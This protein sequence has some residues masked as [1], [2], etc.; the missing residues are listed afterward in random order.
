MLPIGR[1]QHVDGD[2]YVSIDAPPWENGG[3]VCNLDCAIFAGLNCI[4]EKSEPFDYLV[5]D[6]TGR[7]AAVK[8]CCPAR[9]R[10]PEGTDPKKPI[11]DSSCVIR[12][13]S[14]EVE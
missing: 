14:A 2:C 4:Q 6:A 13:G 1:I 5:C 9:W 12:H 8:N 11:Y 3:E 10:T 7:D